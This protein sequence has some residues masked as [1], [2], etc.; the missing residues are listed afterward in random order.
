MVIALILRTVTDY[1]LINRQLGAYMGIG[2]ALLLLGIGW[3]RYAKASPQAPVFTVCGSVLMYLVVTE[4]NLNPKFHLLPLLPAHLLLIVSGVIAAATTN[5]FRVRL[6][7]SIGTVGMALAAIVLTFHEAAPDFRFLIVTLL[8][9]NILGHFT[10]RLDRCAWVRW[11]L[12]GLTVFASLWWAYRIILPVLAEPSTAASARL[13]LPWFLAGVGLFGCA[14]LAIAAREILAGKTDRIGTYFLAIPTLTV[15]WAFGSAQYL[16][17]V[18]NS[19]NYQ[20]NFLSLVVS[21]IHLVV[22]WV[23]SR[24]R[25]EGQGGLGAI[26][27][28]GALLLALSLPTVMG[29][30]IYALPI[31]S[32]AAYALIIFSG[33][34]QSGGARLTSY[35][36]QIHATVYLIFL[37]ITKKT[38]EPLDV[39]VACFI[40]TII[41]YLHYQ[42]A[43]SNRPPTDI[44]F[45]ERY[46]QK[47]FSAALLLLMALVSGFFM[48]EGMTSALISGDSPGRLATLTGLQSIIINGTAAGLVLWGYFG[49]D[50]EKRNIAIL[51]IV[52]GG[53]KVFFHDLVAAKGLPLVVS[54]LSFGVATAVLSVIMSRWQ[55]RMATP[56]EAP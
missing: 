20:I 23:L 21:A 41:S 49:R 27:N 1:G 52:I 51:V 30:A 2:Y 26:C 34:C 22:V 8:A 17:T 55:K 56:D 3:F 9:A 5:R 11:S 19:Y 37:L 12:F 15:L 45:F 6:P 36:L 39:L 40:M 16:T 24:K 14:Y 44:R 10:V 43:R 50:V 42:W 31:L 13:Q 33:F 32:I 29:S 48:V 7:L 4:T 18:L 54:V 35:L 47:D 25:T 28:A 46:D 53:L 38:N